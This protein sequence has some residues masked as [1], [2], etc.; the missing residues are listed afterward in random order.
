MKKGAKHAEKNEEK[1]QLSKLKEFCS[2]TSAHGYGHLTKG[3]KGSKVCW[4][5][6]VFT[7]LIASFGHLYVLTKSYL[8]FDYYQVVSVKPEVERTF[9]D[10][11]ICDTARIS[12]YSSTNYHAAKNLLF[13]YTSIVEEL[14]NVS[15]YF[16]LYP[17]QLY[18]MFI[19]YFA[20]AFFLIANIPLN[21]T[22]TIGV[23]F[24]SLVV[25]CWFKEVK[26]NQS[27]FDTYVHADYL[28]CYTFKADTVKT[29][30]KSQVGT[31]FGLSLIL[32][33]ETSFNAQYH[34]HSKS[35]NID[36]IHIDIHPSKTAPFMQSYGLDL[37]PGISTSIE[38]KQQ[39]YERL[40]APYSNCT[41]NQWVTILSKKY[42]MEPEH[43]FV[44]CIEEHIYKNCECILIGLGTLTE[45]YRDYCLNVKV[46][47]S[48]VLNVSKAMCELETMS[49]LEKDEN[50]SCSRCSWNCEET[51]Y[52]MKITQ[53]KWPQKQTIQSF[54]NKYILS[55]SEHNP[56]REYYQHLLRKLNFDNSTDKN[57]TG[58]SMTLPQMLALLNQN[59]N[60]QSS[61]EDI[62]L[63]FDIPEAL[64][65]TT[66]IT[67]LQSKWIDGYFYRLNIYFSDPYVTVYKQVPSFSFGDFWS[68]VGGVLGIWAGASVLTILEVFSFLGGLLSRNSKTGHETY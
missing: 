53:A 52:N 17:E 55:K 51:K 14:Q 23:Q 34:D 25:D 10:V 37:I 67:E 19:P 44:K 45:N 48:S 39:N 20:R 62:S 4:A 64:L 36:S 35:E 42:L 24:D 29:N 56:I 9:P 32:R 38:L 5:V 30:F 26:C 1:E 7:S 21:D 57:T 61:L 8:Q 13:Q 41:S 49:I 27:N 33:G 59:G 6:V 31:E 66:S 16:K 28:N 11:T 58:K 47:N 46:E 40:Q 50:V 15:K 65:H 2:S 54:F 68:G 3:S 22:K 18:S 60:N 63:E 12:D 43:C